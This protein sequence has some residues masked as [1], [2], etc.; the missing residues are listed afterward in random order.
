MKKIVAFLM[1]LALV[2]L[3]YIFYQYQQIAAEA[4][5]QVEADIQLLEKSYRDQT[6][7]ALTGLHEGEKYVQTQLASQ[8]IND[9][10]KFVRV[11]HSLFIKNG[12]RNCLQSHLT[13]QQKQ[14]NVQKQIWLKPDQYCL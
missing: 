1:L 4:D 12:V 11:Y 14:P 13:Y 7:K 2:G 9:E 5:I 3:A 6:S 10:Q 8:H